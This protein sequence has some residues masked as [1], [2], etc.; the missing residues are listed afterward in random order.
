MSN[1]SRNGGIFGKDEPFD[2]RIAGGFEA[3]VSN[4]N[5]HIDD[6]AMEANPCAE[7]DRQIKKFFEGIDLDI[8]L[9]K[10]GAAPRRTERSGHDNGGD[11]FKLGGN[12][13]ESRQ[14]TSI[15]KFLELRIAAGESAEELISIAEKGGSPATAATMRSILSEGL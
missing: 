5:R 9:E 8:A 10:A 15:R 13:P 2:P 7:A 12:S 1:D 11:L 14:K 6:P 3:H 4:I